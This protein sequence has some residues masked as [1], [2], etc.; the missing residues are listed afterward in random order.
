DEAA[1]Q[2]ALADGGS[3]LEQF[4]HYAQMRLELSK[5][6][7]AKIAPSAKVD[8][9]AIEAFYANNT[10]EFQEPETLHASLIF[11]S[12]PA[13]AGTAKR[14]EGRRKAEAILA[15]LRQGGDFARIATSRSED[16]GS[17]QN[18]GDLGRFE[19]GHFEAAF[20]AVAFALPPGQT[21]GV[22]ESPI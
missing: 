10:S 8:D 15:D 3:S 1:F 14:T 5:F 9:K 11:V 4:R 6:I 13:D 19:R 20:D 17:A 2:K 18:G 7:Q 21:S 16:P 22:V 12:A